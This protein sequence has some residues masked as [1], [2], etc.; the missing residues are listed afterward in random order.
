MSWFSRDSGRSRLPLNEQLRILAECGIRLAAGVDTD[1][2]TR[3]FDESQFEADPFR[4]ALTAMGNQ[5]EDPRQTGHSGF[6]S[7]DVWHFDTECVEGSGAYAAIAT[8]LATL[9]RGELPL[10]S[11]QDHV[12]VDNGVAWLEF[13]LDGERHHWTVAV[14][15]DWVDSKIISRLSTLLTGRSSAHRR[16]T[17]IDLG[18]QDCLIGCATSEQK[19]RLQE[20]SGLTVNWLE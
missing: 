12:D 7:D 9:A 13:V 14:Q 20:R 11:V 1:A 4:L 2:L 15:D 5:A 3:S 19:R 16:F 10:E 8:R 17:Y 18:G 6:L